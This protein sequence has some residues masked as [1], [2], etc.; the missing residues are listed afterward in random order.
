MQSVA[1]TNWTQ[2]VPEVVLDKAGRLGK[3]SARHVMRIK[4]AQ[5]LHR[6]S[7][8]FQIHRGRNLLSDHILDSLNRTITGPLS[9]VTCH[10]KWI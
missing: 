5:V 3:L 8:R 4:K 6:L 7:Q 2:I 9:A 10:M 1:D